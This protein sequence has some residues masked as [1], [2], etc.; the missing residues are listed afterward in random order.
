MFRRK[1]RVECEENGEQRPCPLPWLDSFSMRNF[2]NASVFDDTLPVADGLMEIGTNVPLAEL[3][4]AMEDWFRR[5]SYLSKQ[6]SLR[7][8]ET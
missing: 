7:L 6:G 8:K 2:T 1:I 4:H 3:N 5:K